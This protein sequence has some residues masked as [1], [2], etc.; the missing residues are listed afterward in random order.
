M[1]EQ[2]KQ[3]TL[4][5][6]EI[7]ISSLMPAYLITN[8]NQT[9]LETEISHIVDGMIFRLRLF[10]A[11]EQKQVVVLQHPSTWWEAFKEQ[12]APG[13]FNKR[14][15]VYYKKIIVGADIFYPLLALPDQKHVITLYEMMEG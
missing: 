9:E 8:L 6:I 7:G 10:L 3:H 5:R 13:W 4:K 12:Y 14:Y 11:G 2:I 15:P 1:N